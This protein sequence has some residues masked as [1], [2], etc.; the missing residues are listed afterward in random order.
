MKLTEQTGEYRL[1]V[2]S[3]DKSNTV[4]EVNIRLKTFIREYLTKWE[5]AGK[6]DS[7]LLFEIA[8]RNQII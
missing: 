7:D 6:P 3:I 4:Y 8:E 1:I 5:E 2:F